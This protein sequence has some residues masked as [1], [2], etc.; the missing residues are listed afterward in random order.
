MEPWKI[1]ACIAC[2]VL[3][4]AIVAKWP[5]NKHF[6]IHRK[7]SEELKKRYPIFIPEDDEIN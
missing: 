5:K 7:K 1:I 6:E 4:V 3:L 2:C